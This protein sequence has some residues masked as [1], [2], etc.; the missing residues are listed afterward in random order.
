MI[1]N[2]VI[3][4]G[5]I[6]SILGL[7]FRTSSSERPVLKKFFSLVPPLL[8]CYFIPSLLTTFHIV[9]EPSSSLYHFASNFLLPAAL[10][11]LTMNV[12]LKEI[13]RLGPVS[14]IMF[15][16]GS[17]GIILGGPIA[18]LIIYFISPDTLSGTGS[19]AVWRGLSAIAGSWIGGAPN[20]AAMYGIFKPSAQLYSMVI[21]V[22][23]VISQIWMAIL[24]LGA[25][26]SQLADRLFRANSSTL[27]KII[28]NVK[29]FNTR[30]ARI[31][32]LTDYAVI[33]G[34]AFGF[35]A[36][37]Q[38]LGGKL[39]AWFTNAGEIMERFNFTSGF[40]WLIILSTAFGIG[41]SMTSARNY[42]GAGA[43]KIGTY[44]IYFLV[45]TIGLKM[46]LLRIF[47]NPGLFALGAIWI[48]IHGGLLILV[49]RM[50]RAPFFFLAVGSQ[51][52]I[53]GAASAPVVAAAFN[54]VLAPVGVLLAVFGYVIGTYGGWLSAIIMQWISVILG[55]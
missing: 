28:G 22:D 41:L 49:G 46:D 31:T 27:G 16:T 48:L 14:L 53:G 15:F 34:I 45:A 4:L 47:D 1:K 20:Q 5:L 21:T 30:T 8:L 23:I 10:I 54:P 29:S 44:F 36:L 38:L 17:I 39:A 25:A 55:L 51:A 52:N 50:I 32:S 2:D 26:K 42:E 40:F 18:M 13:F 9:D 19:N 33:L 43:S 7:V 11:L 37:S 35:T 12:N 3:I 6:L 24:L